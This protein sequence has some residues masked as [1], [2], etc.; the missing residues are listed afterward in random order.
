MI[1][2]KLHIGA[3]VRAEG[4]ELLDIHPG[5]HVDHVCD[6]GDLARFSDGSFSE[7][8]ASHVLEHFDFTASLPAALREWR[9]VLCPGGRIYI[10]VPDLEVLARL[11]LLKGRLSLDERLFVVRMI[12]G[13]HIDK[14]D[15]HLAGLDEE[16]LTR[17]LAEAGYANIRRV[18][19][20][21]LFDDAA[22]PSIVAECEPLL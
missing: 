8:Y 12:F 3:S 4:W 10:S 5:P 9:R 1:S 2:R 19:R 11:F 22:V 15:Y 18:A 14:H 7:L 6:A 21:G 16:L 13:G 20:F 17:F